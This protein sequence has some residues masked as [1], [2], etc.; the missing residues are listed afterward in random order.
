MSDNEKLV[1]EAILASIGLE[2]IKGP[3]S[4]ISCKSQ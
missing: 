1:I 2:S 4:K 3:N